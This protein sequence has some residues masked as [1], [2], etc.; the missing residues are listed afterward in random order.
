MPSQTTV[1]VTVVRATA[2]PSQAGFGTILAACYHSQPGA[3]VREFG[4]IAEVTATF[5]A[6]P[7][8]AAINRLATV[9]FSQEPRPTKIK[10][11]KRSTGSLTQTVQIKPLAPQGEGFVW[12]FAADGRA[13]TYTEGAAATIANIVAG[14]VASPDWTTPTA[15]DLT[16]TDVATTTVNVAAATTNVVHS[17]EVDLGLFDLE[18][19]T[20][21]PG[22]ATD[23]TAFQ[24]FDE[25]WY[26]LVLDSDSTAEVTAAATWAE[27][28]IKLFGADA[29]LTDVPAKTPGNVAEVLNTA[30]RD[31]SFTYWSEGRIGSYYAAGAMSYQ[32]AAWDP[33][34]A[35]WKF[36]PVKGVDTYGELPQGRQQAL[37]DQYV[38]HLEPIGGIQSTLQ[39]T[40]ASGEYIDVIRYSAYV[41]ARAKETVLGTLSRQTRLRGK[42]P[43]TDPGIAL[44]TGDLQVFFNGEI[45]D[46]ALIS[47]VVSAPARADISAADIAERLLPDL[48]VDTV[49]AGAIHTVEIR[50]LLGL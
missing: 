15:L 6:D 17:F 30:Q 1:V 8:F 24:G 41:A 34:R 20:A 28:R 35:T 7:N 47:A 50:I 13:I 49:Y 33:G 37:E 5:S 31:K 16:P 38:N 14:L 46:E 43:F 22:I 45:A 4:S 32:F 26:G 3:L 23:L 48:Q 25:D 21:D 29:Y 10:I 27:A 40:V 9:A 42:V 44:T 19:T 18:E 12:S 36:Q 11:G 2:I 39:G